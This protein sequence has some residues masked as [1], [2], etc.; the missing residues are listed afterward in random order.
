MVF[1]E[2]I[3]FSQNISFAFMLYFLVENEVIRKH[4]L[5]LLEFC[6]SKIAIQIVC[7]CKSNRLILM[8]RSAE[9]ERPALFIQFV[10]N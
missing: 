7:S 8:A 6:N 2:I 5:S 3:T 4:N 10:M 9:L 1:S